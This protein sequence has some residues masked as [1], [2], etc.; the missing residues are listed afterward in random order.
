MLFQ[1]K[2]NAVGLKSGVALFKFKI[3]IVLSHNYFAENTFVTTILLKTLLCSNYKMFWGAEVDVAEAEAVA[4]AG[5][6]LEEVG[7]ALNFS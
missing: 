3:K 1:S 4:E 5:A 6:E 2:I 7:V